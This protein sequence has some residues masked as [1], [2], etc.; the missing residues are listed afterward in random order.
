MPPSAEPK[1]GRPSGRSRARRLLSGFLRCA[2]CGGGFYLRYR[3]RYGCGR[4]QAGGGNAC[5]NELNLRE[6]ELNERVLGAVLDQVL[7]PDNVE[8]LLER[9]VEELER[10]ASRAHDAGQLEERLDQIEHEISN[11]VDLAAELGDTKRTAR[12]VRTLEAEADELRR[13]LAA[14][15]VSRIDLR[16]AA[17]EALGELRPALLESTAQA[18]EALRQLFGDERLLVYPDGRVEGSARLPVVLR[19]VGAG[20]R[21]RTCTPCGNGS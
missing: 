4:R 13:S 2:S 3:D 14:T 17:R 21:T 15:R 19:E 12:K 1:L 18:R 8:Y 11:L 16:R 9:T 10:L 6:A 5:D 7:C 20:D